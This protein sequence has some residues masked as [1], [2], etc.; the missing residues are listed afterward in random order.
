[1]F[2]RSKVFGFWHFQLRRRI[3]QGHRQSQ[4]SE[5]EDGKRNMANSLFTNHFNWRNAVSLRIKNGFKSQAIISEN[6]RVLLGQV[7]V[8]FE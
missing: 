8:K 3:S 6:V 1:M 4:I 7:G 5:S 2:V